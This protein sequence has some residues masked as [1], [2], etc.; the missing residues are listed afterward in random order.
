MTEISQTRRIPTDIPI[1]SLVAD[2]PT[3][4]VVTV[5]VIGETVVPGSVDTASV[6]AKIS[7][8]P[9][10][11]LVAVMGCAEIVDG[12]IVVPG[13]VV[14]YVTSCPSAVAGMALP[15]PEAVY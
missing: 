4:L 2:G 14:V 10:T 7:V 12:G 5:L 3:I 1:L 11:T 8:L 9:F 15:L 6:I 13:I